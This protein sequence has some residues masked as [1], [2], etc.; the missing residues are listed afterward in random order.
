MAAGAVGSKSQENGNKRKI[1]M[2]KDGNS[3]QGTT[4]V[5]KVKLVKKKGRSAKLNT[6]RQGGATN[7]NKVGDISDKEEDENYDPSDCLLGMDN[8][9]DNNAILRK[10]M[11]EEVRDYTSVMNRGVMRTTAYTTTASHETPCEQQ[12][13]RSMGG[14]ETMVIMPSGSYASSSLTNTT[15]ERD[16]MNITECLGNNYFKNG[17]DGGGYAGGADTL[18]HRSNTSSSAAA[19]Q[20]RTSEYLEWRKTEG[21]E[22]TTLEDQKRAVQRYVREKLFSK[23]KFITSDDELDYT[24]E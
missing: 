9:N 7:N 13:R 17:H 20:K 4:N 16:E 19:A 8:N 23:L 22:T 24:G 5:K 11:E 21:V 14:G 6:T 10:S 2:T 3:L 18:T 15:T 12:E 1:L